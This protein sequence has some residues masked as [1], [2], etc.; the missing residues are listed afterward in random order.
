[1]HSSHAENATIANIRRILL[2]IF[3]VGLVGTA[4]ELLLLE[5]TE[6][7]AQLTPLALIAIGAAALAWSFAARRPASMR[8]LQLTMMLFVLSGLVGIF[9][10]YR[11]NVEFELEMYPS[12]KGLSL[13]KKSIQ[14]ATPALAPGT[15]IQ[16]GLIGLAYTYR[17]PMLA[18]DNRENSNKR[19]D[20][21]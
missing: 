15:M 3:T 11:G 13:F 9:L 10:H 4:I 8:V 17:H 1:M 18:G 2:I 14:G 19:E 16:L 12:L 5:H 21:A 20:T 6:K 7:V